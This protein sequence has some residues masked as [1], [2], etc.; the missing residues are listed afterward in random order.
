MVR[1]KLILASVIII[2]SISGFS[3]WYFTSFASPSFLP[4]GEDPKLIL[5]LYQI[6]NIA[7]IQGFG[8][9]TWGFHNGIDFGVNAT[10]VIVAPHNCVVTWIQFWYNE[11]GGHWQT[12]VRLKINQEWE[13]EIAFESWALNETYGQYQRDAI[14]VE[15][16]QILHVN[17][18]IGSLLVH[19]SGAH[20]HFGLLTYGT[21]V[22][23]YRYFTPEAKA[24]FDAVFPHVNSTASPCV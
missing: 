19:G 10:T 6:E 15:V 9:L 21:A 16:G 17:E 24:I 4:L 3:F 14:I 5:P 8:N 20:I 7:I 11:K 2:A 22:C 1:K 23:P 12:N 18:T 13:L